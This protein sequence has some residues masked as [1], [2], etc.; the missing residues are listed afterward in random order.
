ML[1]ER[2]KGIFRGLVFLWLI[3]HRAKASQCFCTP[4]D[5]STPVHSRPNAVSETIGF[6]ESKTCFH[7]YVVRGMEW[8]K[9]DKTDIYI[10]RDL[11]RPCPD[12]LIKTIAANGFRSLNTGK[13]TNSRLRQEEKRFLLDNPN[14]AQCDFEVQSFC[15]WKNIQGGH[16]DFDWVLYQSSTPTD[17]TGPKFDHTLNNAT[18]SYI[19]T[20]SSAP[21]SMLDTAWI[22]SPEIDA[23]DGTVHCFRFWY[24]MSGSSIGRLNVYQVTYGSLPGNLVWSLTGEQGSTWMEGQVPL[25][26]N[27]SYSMLISGIVGNGYQGDIAIDDVSVSAG[28]CEVKPSIASRTDVTNNVDAHWSAWSSFTPCS[29]TCG[30]GQRIKT[31]HCMHA[32]SAPIGLT[33]NGS[34]VYLE[35]CNTNECPVDGVPLD[36]NAWSSCSASC[37]DGV[38]TR[39]RDCYFPP[40]NTHGAFCSEQLN[41]TASCNVQPCPSDGSWSEWSNWSTCTHT[42]GL[43]AI[44]FRARVCV[45]EYGRPQGEYCLGDNIDRETC[46]LDMCAVD[47]RW[48]TWSAFTTCSKT[49]GG[50]QRTKTRQCI[51]NQNVQ[52]ERNCTGLSF[53]SEECNTNVCPVDGVLLSWNPWSFCSVSCNGGVQYRSRNCYFPQ[54]IPHGTDC[55]GQ[56]TETNVC[57]IQECPT[58]TKPPSTTTLPASDGHWSNWTSW[59]VCTLTCGGGQQYRERQCTYP[60]HTLHGQYCPGPKNQTQECNSRNC[61][62]DG[63]WTQWSAYSKC[64]VSCASGFQT[65]TRQCQFDPRYDRGNSCPGNDTSTQLCDNGPCPVDGEFE[66]W[67]TWNACPVTC[68]GGIQDRVRVCHFPPNFPHGLDCLGISHENQT[69]GNT[70]CPVDGVLTEWS[71]WADCTLTCGGG[72]RFRNRTCYFPPDKPHGHECV[73][74]LNLSIA[75]S[76]Q[77]CPVDGV[78]NDWASWATCSL[79]C[80]GGSQKRTRKCH[81]DGHRHGTPCAGPDTETRD[82]STDHCPI[83][84]NWNTWNLWTSCSVTCSNGTKSRARECY[85]LPNEPKGNNCSGSANE[86]LDCNLGLCPVDG[87]WHSWTTWSTCTVTCGNGTSSRDR[88]C[89]FPDNTPHG[90]NC[91]GSNS[92]ARSCNAELCPVDGNYTDW[93]SW[94]VCSKTCGGGSQE[95]N[96]T[97]DYDPVA[98]HGNNCSLLGANSQIQACLTENCPVNGIWSSWSNFTA[99][100]VTCGGGTQARL[101]KCE[102][103][104]GYPQGDTCAGFNNE[105]QQCN[106]DLCSVDGKLSAW[107]SWD[108]CSKSCANGTQ[109]RHRTCDYSPPTAPHGKACSG[110]LDETIRCHTEKCPIAGHWSHWT[111]FTACSV[112]CA[113][114]THTRNRTC[115]FDDP[116]APHLSEC[117]GNTMDTQNCNTQPCPVDG[118]WGIWGSW[119][120]CTVT[121]GG[122][123]KVRDRTCD[124]PQGVDHGR[125]CTGPEHEIDQCSSDLC[126]VDGKFTPWSAW[127]QCTYSCGNGDQTRIRK[128]EFNGGPPGTNCTGSYSETQSCSPNSCPVN[129][130]WSPWSG[131]VTCSVSCGGGT[132]SRNRTCTYEMGK[133]RGDNCTGPTNDSKSCGTDPCPVDGT[134][135]QWS[136]F[137]PCVETCGNGTK[138]RNRTCEYT[139][140]HPHGIACPG[141]DKDVQY[142]NTEPC[143]VDGVWL[144]WTDWTACNATCGGGSRNRTRE[145]KFPTHQHGNYCV[146]NATETETCSPNLCPVN[147]HWSAWGS[148]TVCSV[149]CDIGQHTRNRTCEY[150]KVA[151]HGARCPGQDHETAF[152]F[153]SYCPRDGVW[154]GWSQWS[155]C[156]AT[157]GDG[158]ETRGR[159]CVNP[160]P[161]APLG[162]DC[163]GSVNET[164]ACTNITDCPVDGYWSEWASWSTCSVTCGHGDRSRNR[165]CLFEQGKPRGHDCVGQGLQTGSCT[166]SVC[167]VDGYWSEWASWSTCSVTCGHG[168]RSRYRTCLFE[169]GKPHGRD[170]VGQGLQTGSCTESD[171]PVDGVWNTWAAWS[172]CN[173]TC[174]GGTKHRMRDC[175]FPSSAQ[176]GL[177]CIGELAEKTTCNENLCPVDGVLEEWMAWTTCSKTCGGGSQT[178]LRDC[179]FPGLGPF[180]K[181]C[182]GHTNESQPCNPQVCTAVIITPVPTTAST[183]TRAPTSPAPTVPSTPGSTTTTTKASSSITSATAA[184]TTTQTTTSTA[185]PTTTTT[186]ETTTAPTSVVTRKCHVCRGTPQICEQL[187]VLQECPADKQFCIN[188]L[189]NKE[190]ASR[191]VNR[192]CGT[193]DECDN[194]WH[195]TYSADGKCIGFDENLVYTTDFY[196]EYCCNEDGC[197]KLVHPP[198]T[199]TP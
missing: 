181:P 86:T 169:Q 9:V 167:P 134:W 118:V 141:T 16:D 148:W 50:G 139:A 92:D 153:I 42:C 116:D 80:G 20:E 166:E 78:W 70:D 101:R 94:S 138:T 61:P 47:A 4:D 55:I 109:S 190:D 60:D 128:C 15:S 162:K 122:G 149:S 110:S 197:N 41:E 99:C 52:P 150:D 21:R 117:F 76:S 7:G 146:G 44:R 123:Q 156:S 178:R 103:T 74:N 106:T 98:P 198:I 58:T 100:T 40:N 108:A 121:C 144:L 87:V 34:S 90:R 104:P 6:M 57:N 131:W 127:T 97:C 177:F 187:Y 32:P 152:C 33:C 154:T 85:F 49:C 176:P 159:K 182:N 38:R 17:G 53:I 151:P 130:D 137:T 114:G 140:G 195:Q 157:C 188:E 105:T 18:G 189:T 168:D 111:N 115:I 132:T 165:T 2:N 22:Q 192:R 172:I 37:D 3:I 43:G 96:R 24:H 30:G 10:R 161:S 62:V 136:H 160:V 171:C 46:Q 175:Y 88:V 112:T 147:G 19:F 184:A 56:L 173:V 11:L 133:P 89:D 64:S 1:A 29:E 185:L 5:S 82:C 164:Q 194:G 84:G 75:C 180:G 45:F 119:H 63:I 174:G 48:S 142:C 81:Y 179:T 135:G 196:C 102:Y 73:G 36:W 107:G 23:T 83:D 199:W 79:T 77:S 67:S 193:Q 170:C 126:P 66:N 14:H 129:G 183:T 145:C 72:Y 25:R 26:S 91:T 95:R 27:H 125:N 8:M 191:T 39:T 31:R 93:G 13:T 155:T 51:L 143:P 35:Q 28:Y 186:S 120:T 71:Q 163:E 12:S 113:G 68:G 59:T 65:R 69:C 124:F 158:I 54:N